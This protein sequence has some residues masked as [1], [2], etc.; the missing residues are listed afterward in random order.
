MSFTGRQIILSVHGGRLSDFPIKFIANV[1]RVILV[2]IIYFEKPQMCQYLAIFGK[3]VHSIDILGDQV[4]IPLYSH[5]A[6]ASYS[7][8]Q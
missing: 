7:V 5:F 3:A 1:R 4:K 8:T 2:D 6:V